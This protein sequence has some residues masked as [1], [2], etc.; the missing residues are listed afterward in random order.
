L[1]RPILVYNQFRR[2]PTHCFC[3]VR[4]A[5]H[6]SQWEPALAH[7]ISLPILLRRSE[8]PKSQPPRHRSPARLDANNDPR[9]RTFLS[10]SLRLSLFICLSR[11]IGLPLLE[12]K[13]LLVASAMGMVEASA[14]I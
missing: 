6:Q 3:L 12:Q 13:D 2:I 5:R 14:M 7:S 1:L 10:L 4:T 11:P 9:R 8:I